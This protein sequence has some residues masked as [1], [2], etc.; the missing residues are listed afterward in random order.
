MNFP[1][2]EPMP[3]E[4]F[5]SDLFKTLEKLVFVFLMLCYCNHQISESFINE[6]GAQGI[7]VFQLETP[8]LA[9]CLVC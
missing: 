2:Y 6:K 4:F 1:K 5:V 3:E 7:A 9:N 8:E